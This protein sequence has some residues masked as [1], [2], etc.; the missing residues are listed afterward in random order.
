VL[1]LTTGVLLGV[2]FFG[3]LWWTIRRG[4]SSEHAAL[5]FFASLFLRTSIVLAGFYVVA[6]DSWKTLLACILGFVA[7]RLVVTW[8]TRLPGQIRPA[9]LPEGSH[10]P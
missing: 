3:G 9:Q 1:A 2:V 7:A 10:A 6:S 8:F 5:W 4:L